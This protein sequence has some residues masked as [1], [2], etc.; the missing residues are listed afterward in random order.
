MI[1]GVAGTK[2]N[3]KRLGEGTGRVV[4]TI[5]MM[6]HLLKEEEKELYS[7]EQFYKGFKTKAFRDKFTPDKF[8]VPC[9]YVSEHIVLKEM[10]APLLG[11]KEED[12]NDINYLVRPIREFKS[13]VILLNVHIL[14]IIF[15]SNLFNKF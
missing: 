6:Y 15:F 10:L 2:Y 4:L 14:L 3:K 9:V 7:F 5:A 12:L 11:C 13:N 8:I 1:I